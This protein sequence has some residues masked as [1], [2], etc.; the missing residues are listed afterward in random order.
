M[1]I[2]D[3]KKVTDRLT[4]D[5]RLRKEVLDMSKRENKIKLNTNEYTEN[6]IR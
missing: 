6:I 5:E 1:N 2:N 3:Y 4:P